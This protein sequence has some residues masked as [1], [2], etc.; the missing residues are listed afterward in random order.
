LRRENYPLWEPQIAGIP[1]NLAHIGKMIDVANAGLGLGK[2][3][4]QSRLALYKR[5]RPPIFAVQ[6]QQVEG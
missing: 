5:A 3:L 4:R 1:P 2:Q 6:F